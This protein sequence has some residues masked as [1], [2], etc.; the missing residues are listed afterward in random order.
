MVAKTRNYDIFV[1]KIYDYALIDRF[2]GFP[3]FIDSP[4]SYATLVSGISKR[5]NIIYIDNKIN[6]IK[7]PG[8][9]SSPCPPSPC[10]PLAPLSSTPEQCATCRRGT[11]SHRPCTCWLPQNQWWPPTLQP[12]KC[13]LLL[14][15]T[16]KTKFTCCLTWSWSTMQRYCNPGGHPG[17]GWIFWKDFWGIANFLKIFLFLLA[18]KQRELPYSV[19]ELQNQTAASE[20]HQNLVQ[21]GRR[22][23]EVEVEVRILELQVLV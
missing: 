5:D 1:V 18:R 9:Y 6:K 19:L 21:L 8:V 4:T 20:D 14:K 10:T 22:S 7:S 15:S 23:Q 3:G 17:G 12:E 16:P 13:V 2:W 11:S